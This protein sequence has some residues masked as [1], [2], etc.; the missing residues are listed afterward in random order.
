MKTK[1]DYDRDRLINFDKEIKKRIE[2]AIDHIQNGK[3]LENSQRDEA[4]EFYCLAINQLVQS[5]K[6][7]S[8]IGF[9]FPH[10]EED[11]ITRLLFLFKKM[12]NLNYQ[13]ATLEHIQRSFKLNNVC[14]VAM[15]HNTFRLL[16]FV[17]YCN[18]VELQELQNTIQ[19]NN[20]SKSA[21]INAE[22]N[23]LIFDWSFK[24]RKKEAK[25]QLKLQMQAHFKPE[26]IFYFFSNDY[27][28]RIE[29]LDSLKNNFS[30]SNTLDTLD[31][32]LKW[33]T[34][35]LMKNNPL[36]FYKIL[37]YL[38]ELIE[39]LKSINYTLT[40]YELNL[41]APYFLKNLADLRSYVRELVGNI[42][43]SL[44]SISN[45]Y[46]C[47]DILVDL[48][49]KYEIIPL[50]SQCIEQIGFLIDDYGLEKLNSK[51]V[52]DILKKY[53]R[54]NN[55]DNLRCKSLHAISK[56]K[57][58]SLGK[59]REFMTDSEISKIPGA[60]HKVSNLNSK[61][62]YLTEIVKNLEPHAITDVSQIKNVILN[63][64]NEDF[65]I[66]LL[67]LCNIDLFLSSDKKKIYLD[68][69]ADCLVYACVKKL[70]LIC[71][72]ILNT[73][74]LLLF[75]LV[76]AIMD[77]LELIFE[78]QLGNKV[79][80][81]TI[82]F[83]IYTLLNL[84]TKSTGLDQLLI[85]RLNLLFN[86]LFNY[87]NATYGF[88]A[89]FELL[90][91]VI[92]EQIPS[93]FVRVTTNEMLTFIRKRMNI[94]FKHLIKDKNICD[95]MDVKE[96]LVFFDGL[97]QK[98]PTKSWTVG[99]PREDFEVINLFLTQMVQRTDGIMDQLRLVKERLSEDSEL[100]II[101]ST[102]VSK[103]TGC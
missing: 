25:H 87:F 43:K 12:K 99:T 57:V 69:Y 13:S 49:E 9:C 100:S 67:S 48:I 84:M 93:D 3:A 76:D 30:T 2:V 88:Q 94:F 41:F 44:T 56:A 17:N 81:K 6:K 85:F 33:I 55:Y 10:T 102:I 40:D 64:F 11:M 65:D 98:N 1:V 59:L 78:K 103:I 42:F 20:W 92:N 35:M 89:I 14:P 52:I 29:I 71:F 62:V 47:S 90:D 75:S 51:R 46:K 54:D 24:I 28:F 61:P 73:G 5:V 66:A 8:T 16:C 70:E 91:D 86:L 77:T 21:R 18:S 96:M 101:L 22:N 63:I 83:F 72:E 95:L 37:E 4:L 82:K 15:S 97:I 68:D 53:Y 58:K 60:L 74:S 39:Y 80:K 32:V 23:G 34:L 50:S 7:F 27:R 31:L 36:L 19:S 38:T 45:V 79:Q 26:P